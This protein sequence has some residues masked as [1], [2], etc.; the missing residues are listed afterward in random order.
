MYKGIVYQD[1]SEFLKCMFDETFPI[2]RKRTRSDSVLWRKP[3]YQQ[4]IEQ[5]IDNTK[6][7]P[8]TSITLWLRTE[9]GRSVGVT[10]ASS[11]FML[12]FRIP[13]P[14]FSWK[15]DIHVR[16]RAVTRHVT[17]TFSAILT[18][19]GWN[20]HRHFSSNRSRLDL[21]W[22]LCSNK[23]IKGGQH[24]P[25]I[26]LIPREECQMKVTIARVRTL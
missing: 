3:L 5:P 8:Q 15:F 25:I 11:I 20:H 16:V 12:F 21:D 18:L 24:Y 23:V 10:A 17:W 13:L 19:E 4:N 14:G 6:T 7:P 2:K 9:L 26:M 22:N 1:N